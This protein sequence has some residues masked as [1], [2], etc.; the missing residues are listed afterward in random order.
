MAVHKQLWPII[1]IFLLLALVAC[2]SGIDSTHVGQ[3]HPTQ[4]SLAET[5]PS[6]STK[7]ASTTA[8]QIS[9]VGKPTTPTTKPTPTAKPAVPLPG[10]GNNGSSSTPTSQAHQLAQYVSL[11][12]NLGDP[13]NFPPKYQEA[14]LPP[15][16][17]YVLGF[18]P[19]LK[20]YA[21]AAV[22]YTHLTLPTNREV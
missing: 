21:A 13:P 2:S 22:S 4:T 17:S 3:A 10:N 18:V 6:S 7:P 14:D 5:T 12:L 9:I 20:R 16:A 1:G 8:I 15:D 11:A 19:L